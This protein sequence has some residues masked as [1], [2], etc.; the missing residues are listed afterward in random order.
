MELF[1]FVNDVIIYKINLNKIPLYL[2]ILKK[3]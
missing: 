3:Y 1:H 2:I